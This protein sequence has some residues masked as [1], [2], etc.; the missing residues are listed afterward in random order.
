[1]TSEHKPSEFIEEFVSGQHKNHAYKTVHTATGERKTVCK[2]RG[3]TLN[4]STSQLVNFEVI[5]D[6]VIERTKMRH[7]SVHTEMKIKRKRKAGEGIVSI[8][9]EPENK[10]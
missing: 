3:L 6:M 10:M 7:V 1:M 8:I 9:S 5:K 4:Y 2:I